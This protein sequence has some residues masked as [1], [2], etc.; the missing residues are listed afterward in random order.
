MIAE[1]ER[2]CSTLPRRLGTAPI[3][4]DSPNF[5]LLSHVYFPP[6]GSF[7]AASTLLGESLPSSS[8]V[9]ALPS[10]EEMDKLIPYFKTYFH[11]FSHP[12][13]IPTFDRQLQTF[14]ACLTQPEAERDRLLDFGFMATLFTICASALTFYQLPDVPMPREG[15]VDRWTTAAVLSLVSAKLL[16]DPTV[17]AIRAATLLA[18]AHMYWGAGEGTSACIGLLTIAVEGAYTLR[19]NYD[20]RRNKKLSFVECEDRRGVFWNLF[21]QCLSMSLINGQSWPQFD[22][23]QIDTELPLDCHDAELL[24]GEEQ[25]RAISRKRIASHQVADYDTFDE[26]IMTNVIY[27]TRVMMVVKKI[28]IFFQIQ[29]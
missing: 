16:S 7:P 6:P 12:I 2:F 21:T 18:T 13:H 14:K 17:E 24:L 5:P 25:A 11:W 8:L 20:P 19:L 9:A 28:V 3:R 22:L 27:K 4:F 23:D 15:L 1:A 26:T 10:K 29:K